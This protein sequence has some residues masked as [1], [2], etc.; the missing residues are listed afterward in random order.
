MPAKVNF[1]AGVV[2]EK[3]IV[4]FETDS[5]SLLSVDDVAGAGAGV[6]LKPNENPP[7]PPPVVVVVVVVDDGAGAGVP[8]KPNEK[9]PLLPPPAAALALA[10][11]KVKPLPVD[12]LGVS[13]L[14]T[15]VTLSS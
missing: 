6:P 4:L 10:E 9:P 15:A 7:L 2:K 8:L 11:L 12:E 5:P 13:F 1:E 14:S 3:P